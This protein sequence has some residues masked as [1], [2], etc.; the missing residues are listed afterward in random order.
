MAYLSLLISRFREIEN[1]LRAGHR[2]RKAAANEIEI[3]G[4]ASRIYIYA[5]TNMCAMRL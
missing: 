2:Q 1:A 3:K 5:F 4:D